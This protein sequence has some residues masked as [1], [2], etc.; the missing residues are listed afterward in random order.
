L[1]RI[2]I[3]KTPHFA[4]RSS[5]KAKQKFAKFIEKSHFRN[6]ALELSPWLK[7]ETKTAKK[8]SKNCEKIDRI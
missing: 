5:Q 4:R 6:S 2:H 7:N 8:P 3:S 1:L